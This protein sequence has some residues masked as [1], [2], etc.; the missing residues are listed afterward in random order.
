MKILD[1]LNHIQLAGL[2][3]LIFLGIREKTDLAWQQ[4]EWQFS[5]IPDEAIAHLDQ[6]DLLD[7]MTA[8]KY[9]AQRVQEILTQP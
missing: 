3:T 7:Q 9:I 2:A 6:M 5:D 4:S 8:V 1:Q